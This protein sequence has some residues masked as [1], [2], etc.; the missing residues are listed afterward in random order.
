MKLSSK[1][2]GAL[3]WAQ[4]AA[5]SLTFVAGSA[6][7]AETPDW[8]VELTNTLNTSLGAVSQGQLQVRQ[9]NETPME[10]IYEVIMSSGEILHTNR[11]GQFLMTGELYMTRPEGLVNL[12]AETRK[13]QTADLIANMAEE[14]MIIFSPESDPLATIT[15][16]TD[17]DCTFCRRLHGDIEAINERG[18]EVRY[19]AYPRGGRQSEAYPKMISVW[20]ASDRKR[21]LTQAKNGQNLPALECQ[22]PVISQHTI[23]N[24]I[25]ISGTPAIVL[26]DGTVIPG[27]MEVDRLAATVLGQ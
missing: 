9:V 21:A 11:S 24:Q 8:A 5:V 1:L 27:Y 18:I 12:T 6:T 14:D 4:L 17:V 20:C 10:G 2:N 23:G 7:A 25:G 16:F 26:Q 3:R 19:V 22:N 15:V 13:G